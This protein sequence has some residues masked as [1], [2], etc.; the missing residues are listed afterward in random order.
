ML[1]DKAAKK[2]SVITGE[3]YKR[4]RMGSDLK[5]ED[6]SKAK[7]NLKNLT[8]ASSAD[9]LKYMVQEFGDLMLAQFERLDIPLQKRG[10]CVSHLIKTFQKCGVF[11]SV[12]S[13]IFLAAPNSVSN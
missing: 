11:A 7:F 13:A 4:T 1:T 6:P 9:Q 10:E 5:P 12:D 2:G 8:T 3:I